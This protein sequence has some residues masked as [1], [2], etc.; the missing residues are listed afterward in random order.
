VA[1]SQFEKNYGVPLETRVPS[2]AGFELSEDEM[3]E[4][5]AIW[6][7]PA[8]LNVMEKLRSQMT[9][10]LYEWLRRARV[11]DTLIVRGQLDAVDQLY[12]RIENT[13]A[14]WN[15]RERGNAG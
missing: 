5:A 14:E 3:R 10:L 2:G 11:E 13:V 12:T 4:L 6:N 9:R 1:K 7:T 15:K 8:S